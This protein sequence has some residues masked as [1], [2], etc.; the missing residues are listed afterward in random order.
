ME[1]IIQ[2]DGVG[3]RY[4]LPREGKSDWSLR[5]IRLT[6]HRGEHLAVMGPNGSG[7]STLAKLL[8]GLLIPS[9]GCIVVDGLDTRDGKTLPAVRRKVGMVFQNPDNQ[10]VGTT[11]KDDVAFGMENAG[12]PRKEML[13]RIREVL[14]RVGLNGLEAS[15]PHHL[16]GG[17]K[18]RL[19]IAGVLAM[20]PEVVVFDEATSMLDPAGRKEVLQAMEELHRT[21]TTV[22]HITH[23]VREAFCAERVLILENGKIQWQGSPRELFLQSEEVCR[24]SLEVPLAV[25]LKNRLRERGLPVR[26]DIVGTEELVETIWT[27]LSR[28]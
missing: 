3:F 9:E 19:A 16:S 18:Q 10:I 20:R 15:S 21:G 2:L 24:W 17:Q 11:V 4:E 8:N 14:D 28:N 6:V 12:I 5:G 13:E 27:L 22:I 23:S 1:P 25:E 7:K 26:Q